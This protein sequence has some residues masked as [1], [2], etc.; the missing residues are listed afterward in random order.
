MSNYWWDRAKSGVETHGDITAK[1]VPEELPEFKRL[2][3]VRLDGR[4][5]MTVTIKEFMGRRYM[6]GELTQ[7]NGRWV[8]FDPERV[9]DKILDPALVPLIEARVC[10]IAQLDRSFIGNGPR[11]FIDEKRQRWVRA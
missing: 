6:S 7:P 10:E 11:E 5:E 8:L 1:T 4:A 3:K 2:Y 9:A